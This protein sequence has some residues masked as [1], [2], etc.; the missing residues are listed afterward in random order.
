MF[1]KL[2]L[3]YENIFLLHAA[4]GTDAYGFFCFA[5]KARSGLLRREQGLIILLSRPSGIEPLADPLC[6]QLF[7]MQDQRG[8]MVFRSISK[9]FVFPAVRC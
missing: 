3:I 6:G 8:R 9:G 2:H 5:G 1:R 7:R 4:V